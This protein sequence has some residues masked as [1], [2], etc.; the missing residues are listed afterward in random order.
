MYV[1]ILSQIWDLV[2][3]LLSAFWGAI[4]AFLNGILNLLRGLL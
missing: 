4:V 1:P 2:S 3:S